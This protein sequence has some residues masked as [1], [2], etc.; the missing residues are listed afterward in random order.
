MKQTS[1]LTIGKVMDYGEDGVEASD[2]GRP[3]HRLQE[4]LKNKTWS[5]SDHRKRSPVR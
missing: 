2:H 5:A 3:R 1:R 4:K